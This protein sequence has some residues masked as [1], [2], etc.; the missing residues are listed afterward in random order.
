MP[1][2]KLTSVCGSLNFVRADCILFARVSGVIFSV[3][4][5]L[6]VVKTSEIEGELFDLEQVR[7]SLAKRL[8][9][10]VGGA[11]TKILEVDGVVE[12]MPKLRCKSC[13]GPLVSSVCTFKLR[14]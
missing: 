10:D 12:M 5:E 9:V 2:K 7:S 4:L 11:A 8:G 14:R 13:R 3:L 1:L 6:Y